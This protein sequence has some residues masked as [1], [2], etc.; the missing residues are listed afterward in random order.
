M[1]IDPIEL[2]LQMKGTITSPSAVA[3]K[4]VSQEENA[5]GSDKNVAG[6]DKK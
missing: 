6:L 4:L 3:E 1:M 5:A 2:Y